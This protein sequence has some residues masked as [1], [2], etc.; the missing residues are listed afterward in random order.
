[1]NILRAVAIIIAVLL[2]G[3]ASSI[4]AGQCLVVKGIYYKVTRVEKYG[5][6]VADDRGRLFYGPKALFERAIQI[7]CLALERQLKQ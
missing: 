7:D 5:I 1:M 2:S 3:C 4:K 6:V